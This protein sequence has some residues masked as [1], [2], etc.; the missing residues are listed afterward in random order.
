MV[1]ADQPA[2]VAEGVAGERYCQ[3]EIQDRADVEAGKV[4]E[5]VCF[6]SFAGLL[7]SL[8][9]APRAAMADSPATMAAESWPSN[10]L[11]AHYDGVGG[12]GSYVVVVG[13]DC[14]GGG[15]NLPSD[16][17]DRIRSTRHLR[18]GT[19]KHW[20]DWGYQGPSETTGGSYGTIR[21][22]TT[23]DQQVT[24]IQYYA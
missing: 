18:C 7:S 4:A 10:A 9:V 15:L 1:L 12:G 24:S 20:R 16:W 17:N 22:L 8:G 11:A 5:L 3:V 13:N 14:N 21:S 19:I 6:D 23:L 2:G